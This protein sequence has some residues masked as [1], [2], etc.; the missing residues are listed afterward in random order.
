MTDIFYEVRGVNDPID[1]E[2]VKFA[3]RKE[4]EEYYDSIKDKYPEASIF[5]VEFYNDDYDHY[6][7]GEDFLVGG[8][9]FEQE[10]ENNS[11]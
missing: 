3:S 5:G 11:E 2:V 7:R 9:A 4:A 10:C 6:E 8:Y 1:G